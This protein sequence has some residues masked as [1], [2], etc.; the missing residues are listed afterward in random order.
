MYL[1]LNATCAE[2]KRHTGPRRS[3]PTKHFSL[4]TPCMHASAFAHVW[5]SARV[6]LLTSVIFQILQEVRLDEGC[7]MGGAYEMD[8]FV[9]EY[10]PANG[11]MKWDCSK[12]ASLSR[13]GYV[14]PCPPEAQRMSPLEI[15]SSPAVRKNAKTTGLRCALV[16]FDLEQNGKVELVV[17]P[18]LVD[19][20]Q[21]STDGVVFSYVK[22]NALLY[23]G[24]LGIS[25]TPTEG[26][27]PILSILPTAPW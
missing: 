9:Q 26:S 12:Q 13:H 2:S 24:K 4:G 27:F 7:S 3:K 22:Q 20:G 5:H 1:L 11:K 10:G 21:K 8:S 16:L 15:G 23:L 17:A 18:N 6:S 19:M 14:I 25:L